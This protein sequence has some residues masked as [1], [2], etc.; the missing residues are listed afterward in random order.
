MCEYVC[1]CVRARVRALCACDVYGR[2]RAQGT[3][4]RAATARTTS[5]TR[6]A[7]VMFRTEAEARDAAARY[8]GAFF[9]HHLGSNDPE[10]AALAAASTETVLAAP[11]LPKGQWF[12]IRG[13]RNTIPNLR[14]V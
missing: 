8:R 11:Q 1:E 6:A 2:A 7:L 5:S 4:A 3:R 9:V 13:S 14:C 10:L 12:S